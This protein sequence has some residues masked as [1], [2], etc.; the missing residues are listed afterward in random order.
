MA[1]F[2]ERPRVG[3]LTIVTSGAAN[4]LN[5][6]DTMCAAWVGPLAVAILLPVLHPSADP[7]D[8]T[9]GQLK[10]KEVMLRLSW[11]VQWTPLYFHQ[12]D[13]FFRM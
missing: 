8:V 11:C 7:R 1:L 13:T 10:G 4:R 3:G 5:T 6:L 2:S 12:Q 9:D